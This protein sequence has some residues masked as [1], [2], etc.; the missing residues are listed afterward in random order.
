MKPIR[1]LALILCACLVSV[2]WGQKNGWREFHRPDMQRF[3]PYENTLTVTN[4]GNLVLKWSYQTGDQISYSCPAV[5][6]GVVYVG[7]LDNNVY[8]LD[9]ATGVKLWSYTTGGQV[10]S[11][12]AVANGVVYVGSNDNNMYALNAKTGVKLWSYATGYWIN[13]A[14]TVENGV[15]YFG[16]NDSYVYALNASS[17]AL[18]WRYLTAQGYNFMSS[19]A[20]ANGVLYIGCGVCGALYA[21]NAS[22]GVLLWTYNPGYPAFAAP[23]VERGVVYS[24][25]GGYSGGGSVFALDASTGAELD[26]TPGLRQS[27]KRHFAVRCRSIVGRG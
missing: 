13:G 15:V 9:A 19:P 7:S 24:A 22:T 5:A 25:S 10:Y 17:G 20:L 6:N 11:A 3:N 16:S 2:A 23:A 26:W 1:I 8:A 21:L 18:L 12:P 4:V 14:P 27:V